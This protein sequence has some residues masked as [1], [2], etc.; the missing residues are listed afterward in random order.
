M[1][2]D[3]QDP[4]GVLVVDKPKGPTSHDVV[5]R[6]RQ[7]C[8]TRRVGHAGTLDPFATGV[9]PVC[10]GKATRL[11]RFL[12][13]G[14]KRYRAIVRLGF[15]T[16]TDDLTGQPL[17]P[18]APVTADAS[19]VE[20]ACRSL[21][22]PQMQLPPAYSARR[23]D[24]RRLYEL[25]RAGVPVERQPTP[26]VVHA[27]EVLALDASDVEL[28]VHCSAGTYVRA[29]ARD[30]GHVLGTGAHLAALRRTLSGGFG[31]DGAVGWDELPSVAGERLVSLDEL[32]PQL[33]AVR[34]SEEGANA[35]RHGRDLGASLVES[36]FPV[37]TPPE[38]MRVLDG[39]GRLLALAVPSG[40]GSV[41]GV[42]P[43]QPVL[44]PDVVLA[45]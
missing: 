45:D 25:A 29:L 33:P 28:D 32:L 26:V 31:L 15:A 10:V 4:S 30:L 42:L 9:L 40:F 2:S 36:G 12:A 43:V 35:V 14:D 39:E 13:A 37:A 44:H 8:G 11:A 19:A 38:R 22:G 18:P 24:G 23:R 16:D 1:T 7:A 6:V 21:V 5:D 3:A 41:G 20:A 17:G 27:L 34:V